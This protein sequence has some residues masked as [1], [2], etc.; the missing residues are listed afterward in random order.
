VLG[1]EAAPEAPRTP[2][3]DGPPSP[4]EG[5]EPEETKA[6]WAARKAVGTQ[7]LAKVREQELAAAGE[8]WANAHA[9]MDA[10]KESNANALAE[11]LKFREEYVPA[12]MRFFEMRDGLRSG[13]HSRTKVATDLKE[14]VA[15]ADAA[16]ADLQGAME[17]AEQAEVSIWDAALMET[18]GQKLKFIRAFSSFKA[19]LG[20]QRAKEEEQRLAEPGERGT[21]LGLLTSLKDLLKELVAKNVPLVLEVG[22]QEP[23]GQAV[24]LLCASGG[25]DVFKVI[26]SLSQSLSDLIQRREQSTPDDARVKTQREALVKGLLLRLERLEALRAA[27]STADTSEATLQSALEEGAQADV[28]AWDAV[29]LGN[30]EQKL[31]FIRAWSSFKAQVTEQREKEEEERFL[32]QGSRE[33]LATLLDTVTRLLQELGAKAVPLP[34]EACMGIA[35]DGEAP[36]ADSF[37]AQAAE[38][39]AA[40]VAAEEAAAAAAA[41]AKKR[42]RVRPAQ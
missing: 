27:V 39:I 18:A 15:N 37:Q 30:A 23:Y 14:Q 26:Q 2:E 36:A 32:Q 29:L 40:A 13:L 7:G 35:E 3:D 8:R 1:S 41:S 42:G 28:G 33:E 31:E 5:E 10:A 19:L 21:F 12:E 22:D 9:Q 17:A 38:L 11:L 16:E 24:D 4:K 6:R 20:E 34:K 25:T